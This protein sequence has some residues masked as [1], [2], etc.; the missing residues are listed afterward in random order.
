MAF[1]KRAPAVSMRS[2]ERGV[3]PD[4]KLRLA[5]QLPSLVVRRCHA[6]SSSSPSA[7]RA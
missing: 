4:V 7:V 5:A 1:A 3:W 2:V 6:P